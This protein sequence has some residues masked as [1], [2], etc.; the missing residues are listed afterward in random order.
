M[1]RILT[2]K[3]LDWFAL[4]Q[5]MSEIKRLSFEPSSDAQRQRTPYKMAAWCRDHGYRKLTYTE[6]EFIRNI[7][8]PLERGGTLTARQS[9]WLASIYSRL[10]DGRVS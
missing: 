4:S 7:A 5:A 6:R 9:Q 8:V 1:G 2:G 10:H 3:G